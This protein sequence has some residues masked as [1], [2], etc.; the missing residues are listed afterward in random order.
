MYILYQTYCVS[1]INTIKGGEN[2][3]T[4]TKKTLTVKKIGNSNTLYLVFKLP[5]TNKPVKFRVEKKD[6]PK[7]RTTMTGIKVRQK[8]RLAENGEP[9][10]AELLSKLTAY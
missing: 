9:P 6:N 5:G 4:G 10:S 1:D 7:N 3:P 8:Y 2:M